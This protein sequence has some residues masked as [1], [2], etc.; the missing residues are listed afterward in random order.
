M[1]PKAAQETP[2][3]F[4][5]RL[6]AGPS[7]APLDLQ[8][9]ADD[10]G[11]AAKV[12]AAGGATVTPVKRRRKQP[13]PAAVR[14]ACSR[15]DL[16]TREEQPDGGDS[17]AKV[18]TGDI[19]ADAPSSQEASPADAKQPGPSPGA[20]EAG[21]A[22]A[23]PKAG[24]KRRAK[25][26][27]PEGPYTRFR[28]A[29]AIPEPQLARRPL[30]SS[31]PA[32]GAEASP[33]AEGAN[34]VAGP[35]RPRHFKAVAW[36]IG[37]LRGF[38]RSRPE[39]L[40]TLVQE[41]RP[42]VLC[43]LE[44]KLQ[45]DSKETDAA[46]EAVLAALPDYE[47]GAF[48]Y[49][50]AKKGYSGVALLR[51]KEADEKPIG[52]E[53]IDLPAASAEGRIIVA[54]YAGFWLVLCYVPNSGDGLKRLEERVGEWDAQ[55]RDKLKELEARKPV[56]LLGDL[57]VAHRDEDIWNVEAPHVAKS[58]GTTPQE[59]ES[60]STL[61]AL[62]FEDAFRHVHPEALGAF[63][64]WSIRAGNRPKNRGLRLDYAVVCKRMLP[65]TSATK[66]ESG[67][68][69]EASSAPPAPATEA[70]PEV[71]PE[72]PPEAPPGAGPAA[73]LRGPTLVDAFHLAHLSPG[74]HCPVGLVLRLS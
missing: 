12:A 62:G 6:N 41:E 55:L 65:Q 11:A 56:V 16:A 4:R 61:L 58:A 30:E 36:N 2:A 3:R 74:D 19:A 25:K 15:V 45:E 1:A 54:E 51:L 70:G 72:A 64:Y 67:E 43:V 5:K 63:T 40:P 32:T 24:A 46:V 23:A 7:Q 18:L 47:V 29:G 71:P 48:H 49:S 33:G 8:E 42:D 60:F 73:E 66:A 44:H 9:D 17:A 59:R 21:D 39:A 13:T 28:E 20:S 26:P 37:G 52:V 68:A 27:K 14:T 57:N 53:C 35:P 22:E 38:L 69:P 31:E 50:T 10:K 34:A